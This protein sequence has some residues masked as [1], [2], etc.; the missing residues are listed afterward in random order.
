M[1]N[2][3]I[4]FGRQIKGKFQTVLLKQAALEGL[5]GIS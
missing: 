2:F 3:R 5:Q 1:E 4:G